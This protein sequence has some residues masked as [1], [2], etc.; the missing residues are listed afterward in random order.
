MKMPCIGVSWIR[1]SQ[2]F[3]VIEPVK[4]LTIIYGAHN[5]FLKKNK[6]NE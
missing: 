1:G 2:I 5:K 4:K 3:G 6:K